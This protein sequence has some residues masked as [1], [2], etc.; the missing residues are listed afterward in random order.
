[1]PADFEAIQQSIDGENSSVTLRTNDDG[2][3]E[4]NENVLLKYQNV[5]PLYAK[6]LLR[7]GEFFRD[8]ATVNI[9]DNDSK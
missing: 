4:H 1:M 5:I 3:V 9:I 6:F 7:E 2:I 8:T